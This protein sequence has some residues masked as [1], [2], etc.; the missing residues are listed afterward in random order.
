MTRKSEVPFHSD[1]S[2]RFVPLIVAAMVYLAALALT[3][4]MAIGGTIE[5]WSA[6][7]QGTLTVQLPSATG[8]TA[9]LETAARTETALQKNTLRSISGSAAM[10]RSRG[11]WYWIGWL[12]R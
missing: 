11:A 6:G 1:A 3:G 10:A 2:R 5:R 12:T 9:A 8:D 7:L 4:A